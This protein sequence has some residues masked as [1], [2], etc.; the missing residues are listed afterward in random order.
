MNTI[1]E[2]IHFDMSED[3]YRKAPCVNISALKHMLKSPAHYKHEL[4]SPDEDK[5]QAHLII[6]TLVHRAIGE[7]EKF[8]YI[9]RPPEF[10]DWRTKASQEWRNAQT[11]PVLTPDEEEDVL[12]C[13]NALQKCELLMELCKRGKQEVACFKRHKR[14]GLMLK[15]RSDLVATDDDGVT[16]VVD[17]KT[18][19]EG[20]ASAVEF[21]RKMAELNYHLQA[22]H[23]G[24]LFETSNFIFIAVEKK[25]F[26]GVGIYILD[27]EDIELGRRTNNALLQ[28]LAECNKTNT[29]PGY[30][31]EPRVIQLP[32]W[33]RKQEM[34]DVL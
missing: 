15:G 26:P 28:K 20:G 30:G 6:G 5:R 27:P 7:P 34:E 23:Y 24:D 29:W 14:T 18:V 10:K 13:V 31:D 3:D 22:A 8:C 11:L 17:L 16:W 2:G 25:G 4:E 33:K 19:P 12:R 9:V 32:A 1:E 21:A